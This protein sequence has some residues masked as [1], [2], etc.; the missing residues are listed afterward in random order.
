[1]I[2]SLSEQDEGSYICEASNG[3][4][5][6]LRTT[7]LLQLTE[8]VSFVKTPRDSR[9]E[10]GGSASFDCAARGRP[11]PQ[12]SWV[13]N[14]RPLANDSHIAIVA[15]QLIV[16]NAS[17]K[18]AGIYQCFVSNSLSK[19]DGSAATL[20]VLPQPQLA[21]SHETVDDGD[22]DGDGG[23][24]DE[25]DDD[26]LEDEDFFK[27]IN[28]APPLKSAELKARNSV[29]SG[30]TSA[31]GGKGRKNKKQRPRGMHR[32]YIYKYI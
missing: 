18:H 21:S 32:L 27:P 9:V 4:G 15:N 22:G 11:P 25:D 19:V 1:M 13:F 6:P 2:T 31:G 10:E 8:P 14:G 7:T 30:G 23:E 12:Q 29:E 24:E 3:V 16:V 28:P 20:E 5:G 26:P 17:K